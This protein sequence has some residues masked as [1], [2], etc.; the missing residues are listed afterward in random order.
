[1][2]S[3]L[4]GV[5]LSHRVARMIFKRFGLKNPMFSQVDLLWSACLLEPGDIVDL[6]SAHVPDRIAGVLGMS[7]KFFEVFDRT[8]NFNDGIVSVRLVD[9][10]YLVTEKIWL[11]AD[12]AVAAFTSASTL[13]KN[14]YMFQSNS[15]DQYSDTTPAAKLP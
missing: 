9:A 10:S 4:Q 8:W 12:N 13:E 2:R 7:G 15:S 6:T 11:I 5:F 1:M 3:G 14:K